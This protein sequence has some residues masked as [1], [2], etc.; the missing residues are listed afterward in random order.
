MLGTLRELGPWCREHAW[1]VAPPRVVF[2]ILG[3]NTLWVRGDSVETIGLNV[4]SSNSTGT[5]QVTGPCPWSVDG[6]P[7]SG[8]IQ[9]TVPTILNPLPFHP[10]FQP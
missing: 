6:I 5:C 8:A 3:E 7:A 1:G 4:C 10:V 2:T 9:V